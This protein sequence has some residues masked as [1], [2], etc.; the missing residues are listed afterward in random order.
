[1]IGDFFFVFCFT[2]QV[3]GTP[4]GQSP[5][6]ISTLTP[7]P[8][9]TH[10]QTMLRT[11]FFKQMM[12]TSLSSNFQRFIQ[13]VFFIQTIKPTHIIIQVLGLRFTVGIDLL[14]TITRE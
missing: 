2:W 4:L 10:T 14:K 11:A 1:M 7:P 8:P 6:T 13:Q 12:N 9:H 5:S 3:V